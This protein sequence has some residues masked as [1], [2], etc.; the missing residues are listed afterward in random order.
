MELTKSRNNSMKWNT[1]G[2]Y[3]VSDTE[4]EERRQ[5]DAA[6]NANIK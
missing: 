3:E 1:M 5:M 4:G 2:K 6:I